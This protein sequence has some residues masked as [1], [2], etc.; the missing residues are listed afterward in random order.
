MG[1]DAFRE[2]AF[3]FPTLFDYNRIVD[4]YCSRPE[5]QYRRYRG[6]MLAWD[7][8]PRHNER[9]VV[10]HNVTPERFGR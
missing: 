5:V 7:I 10:F 4:F 3:M 6:P 8:T 9:A 1:G 2:W